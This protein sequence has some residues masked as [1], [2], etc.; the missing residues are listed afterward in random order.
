MKNDKRPVLC[1]TANSLKELEKLVKA[2]SS[3][4]LHV[5]AIG[6]GHAPLEMLADPY[7]LL[8]SFDIL[9]DDR[10]FYQEK[11]IETLDCINEK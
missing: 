6:A 5:R 10:L 11:V 8:I 1:C 3:M 9:D 7:S 4:S 2:A